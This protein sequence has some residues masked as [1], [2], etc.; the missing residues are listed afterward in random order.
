MKVKDYCNAMLAEVTAWKNKLEA[1][2][3]TADSYGSEQKEKILPLIG[4]LEQEVSTARMRVDQLEKECPSDWSPM[5]NELDDLFGTVGSKVNRAW[6]EI[7]PG[8]VGG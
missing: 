7:E 5:K 8:N 3:K 4:Q 1:M 6:K 2:K